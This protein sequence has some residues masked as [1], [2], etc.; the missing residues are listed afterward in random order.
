MHD[1]G[2]NDRE[3]NNKIYDWDKSD[4]YLEGGMLRQDCG[5]KHRVSKRNAAQSSR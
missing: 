3:D 4:E 1:S 2:T 5:V